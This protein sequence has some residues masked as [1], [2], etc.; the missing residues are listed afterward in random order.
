MT[1]KDHRVDDPN[2]MLE[3][4]EQM[5]KE[6]TLEELPLA[7]SGAAEDL[8]SGGFDHL[9]PGHVG[10]MQIDPE[11]G[12]R[13]HG[14]PEPRVHIET[15]GCQMNEHDT[16]IMYGILAQMGYVKAQGP[17]DA[18]LLLFNTCAVRE[19]AVEHAFGRIGQLKPLKYTNPDLIIGVCGCVPQVEGEVERML[20]KFP[21]LDLIFGTH[22]IH[23]L[24]E[25]VERARNE[26]ETVVDVW[27][28]M[29]DDF[30]DALPV[31]REGDL[32]AW[33]TIMYGCDKHC[34]YCIV[35]TTRG[36]ERS[37]PREVILAEVQEL[38]R[39]GYKEITL[40]G[41]NVNAYGKDLYGRHG[42]G[43][44]DFGDLIELIDRNSPGIERIRFTTNH[45][46]DFT[47]KMV[48]QI[49]RAEK[50]CEWFHLPVQS[51]SDSVLRRMKRSYNRKQ[52]L[53]LIQWVRELI[54]EAVI[55]TDII[56]GF[57]GETEEE[58]RETLSLVE[59]V[60]FDAAFMFMYSERAGTPAA[61]MEDRLSVAEKKER[62]QRLMEVQN[63]VGRAKNEARIGKVYDVLVEGLDKGKP[64]VVFGRTRGNILVTFPGDASLRGQIVPVRITAAG[65]WT[66]EGERVESPIVL[67]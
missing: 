39:Q 65:T 40:L 31:A 51:G 42:E 2:A 67:A 4:V 20:R 62:L 23:R 52:Y 6:G 26:R 19:S 30:P 3:R 28:S 29:G 13:I 46:K 22:N 48:E 32:K 47:R 27:E 8:T 43:A 36:K 55:T 44:F 11:A 57:P 45:P 9:E 34:T 24:P 33:V 21:H 38:A 58:F 15:Y 25:L 61:K 17:E 49:A 53:R 64:D 37:R 18:D 56:V 66:L 35:P 10:R 1:L 5:M 7:P 60:Q 16:E 14:K 54:P 41:Q 50:V 63:R 12:R 59:E